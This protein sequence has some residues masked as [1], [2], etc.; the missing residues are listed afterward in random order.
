VDVSLELYAAPTGNCLRAAMALEEAGIPFVMR[1]VDLRN[2][3]HKRAPYIDLNPAGLV[4]TLVETKPDGSRLVLT[5]SNA[6]ILYAAEQAPGRLMPPEDA[7]ARAV[8]FEQFFFFITDVIGPSGA[9]F[10]LN[11]KQ[12]AEA[13]HLLDARLHNALAGAERFAAASR[14]IAGDAFT[15]ADIAG[16]TITAFMRAHLPWAS[17]P[18]LK[19]WYQTVAP[20]PAVQRTYRALGMEPPSGP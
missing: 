18:N 7:S 17:L 16:F 15:I 20:R 11:N 10:F 4:P 12:Q 14:F 9:S 13:V 8:V 1:M 2:G 3:E 6:I 5:Q 19:R